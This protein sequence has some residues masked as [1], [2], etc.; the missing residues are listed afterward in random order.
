MSPPCQTLECADRLSIHEA[1]GVVMAKF[2]LVF[3]D[4]IRRIP[5][6]IVDERKDPEE[7]VLPGVASS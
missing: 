3:Q 5:D 2:L 6:L 4:D 1:T 7:D